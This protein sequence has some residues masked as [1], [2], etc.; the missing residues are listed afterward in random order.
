MKSSTG[1]KEKGKFSN[2]CEEEK[3]NVEKVLFLL[4]KFCGSG[5]LYHEMAQVIFS[6]QRWLE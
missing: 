2:L 5:A 4:D 3:L 6:A 1:E